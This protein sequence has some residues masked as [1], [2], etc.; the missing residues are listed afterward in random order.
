MKI[1]AKLTED[2][3]ND[4]DEGLQE[5]YRKVETGGEDPHYALDVEG[6]TD[7]LKSALQ[8]ERDKARSSNAKVKELEAALQETE[9]ND[10]LAALQKN[11]TGLSK[12]LK[13][14]VKQQTISD[15]ILEHKGM[16]ALGPAYLEGKVTVD[17]DGDEVFAYV[18]HDGEKLTVSDYVGELYRATSEPDHPMH[19]AEL[20]RLFY[21]RVKSGAGTRP[22]SSEG[23]KMRDKPT[24]RRSVMPAKDKVAYIREHG[25]N[26]FI[27]LPA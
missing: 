14:V 11:F 3:F 22:G 4:L 9:S 27:D 6:L 19:D 21:N 2:K 23:G 25:E 16:K 24:P 5:N 12:T 7:G 8:K 15:A 20:P 17:V 1:L 13:Q 18:E 26:A 10:E